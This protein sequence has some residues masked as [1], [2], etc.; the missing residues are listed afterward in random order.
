MRKNLTKLV[1]AVLCIS[2]VI[3]LPFAVIGAGAEEVPFKAIV[4]DSWLSFDIWGGSGDSSVSIGDDYFDN[5][6]KDAI[7]IDKFEVLKNKLNNTIFDPSNYTV[8]EKDGKVVITLKEDYLKTLADGT[9]YFEAEFE[10][11][12]ISLNLYIIREKITVEDVCYDFRINSAFGSA[13]LHF[14][15]HDF[16]FAFDGVLFE[17]LLYNGKEVDR[18]NY[19]QSGFLNSITIGLSDEYLK[20]FPQGDHYFAVELL[21]ATGIKLRLR[22]DVPYMRGDVSGDGKILADDARLALR[23]SANLI[24]VTDEQK[25]AADIDGDG[26]ITSSDARSI[27]RYSARLDETLGKYQSTR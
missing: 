27:L 1:G 16:P 20:T 5:K 9:Y 17:K 24:S 22:I 15:S 25:T 26:I 3:V 4:F 12:R 13:S 2:M 8:T 11:A 14:S 10:R 6:L 23:A 7:V 21:N 18:A 19:S